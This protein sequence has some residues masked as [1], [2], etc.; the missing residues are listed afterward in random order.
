MKNIAK[1]IKSLTEKVLNLLEELAKPQGNLQLQ[2]IRI[3]NK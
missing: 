3:K 1:S 2:P